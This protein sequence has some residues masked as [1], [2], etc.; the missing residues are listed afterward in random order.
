MVL[1]KRCWS[2]WKK[3]SG[4]DSCSY[5]QRFA[6]S[7]TNLGCWTWNQAATEGHLFP[8]ICYDWKYSVKYLGYFTSKQVVVQKI[9]NL[10]PPLPPNSKSIHRAI[11]I[12]FLIMTTL[13]NSRWLQPC[14]HTIWKKNKK[15]TTTKKHI[16]ATAFFMRYTVWNT[17]FIQPK[18]KWLYA[19]WIDRQYLSASWMNLLMVFP[20]KFNFL[21]FKNNK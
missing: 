9:L 8:E 12:Y 20:G 15:K 6:F 3:C 14:K 7:N 4:S 10:L 18:Q 21:W 19:H 1:E 16:Y 2:A 13:R 17:F 5:S 11:F